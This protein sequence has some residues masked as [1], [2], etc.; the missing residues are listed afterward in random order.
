VKKAQIFLSW[1]FDFGS[2]SSRVKS[3]RMRNIF[4][5]IVQSSMCFTML[6]NV[7]YSY[8]QRRHHHH[9]YRVTNANLRDKPGDNTYTPPPPHHQ[10]HSLRDRRPSTAA[11]PACW[12]MGVKETEIVY[13]EGKKFCTGPNRA[14]K[15]HFLG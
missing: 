14:V 10:R 11:C 2:G 12:A 5:C 7:Q 13:G 8:I 15:A 9:A 3:V 1:R 6:F 4:I